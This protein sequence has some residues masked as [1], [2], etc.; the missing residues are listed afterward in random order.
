MAQLKRC[1]RLTILGIVAALLAGPVL[2][3]SAFAG[4]DCTRPPGGKVDVPKT[5]NFALNST[6]IG[7]ADKTQLMEIAQ[8]YAGN[9]NIEVCL[10]GMTDRSG[11]EDYNKK[12]AMAR[13]EAVEKVLKANGLADNKYQVVGRGQ[14]YGDGSWLDK[15][16]GDKPSESN[17]RVDVLIMSS[18]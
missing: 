9:P 17:R 11:S 7:E 13:A 15:L 10:I 3:V 1:R 4:N 12:L 5:I 18:Q 16:L 14:P 8:R 6:E 2:A